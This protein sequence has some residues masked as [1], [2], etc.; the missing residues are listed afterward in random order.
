MGT[1]GKGAAHSLGLGLGL[2]DRQNLDAQLE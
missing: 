2:G 1:C